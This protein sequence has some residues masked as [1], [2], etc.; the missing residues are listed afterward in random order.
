[1]SDK[2]LLKEHNKNFINWFNERI[3][4]DG[5]ASETIK[6]MSY[7]PKI[8]FIIWNT[9]DISKFSCYTKSKDDRSIMQNCGVV[10]EA[11]S[12]YFSSS[13]DKNPIIES[14]L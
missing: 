7:M 6:W 1:M 8:K 9:Y 2:W 14:R 3:S 4:N 13:K 5:S 12:M 11:E 10:V